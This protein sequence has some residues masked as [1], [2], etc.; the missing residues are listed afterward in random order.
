MF[1]WIGSP[2]EVFNE[3]MALYIKTTMDA[4]YAMMEEEAPKVQAFMRLSAS[5]Q[6]DCMPS[7]EYL[8]AVPYRDDADLVV[9]ILAYYDEEEYR[10]QCPEPE[11]DW[12]LVHELFT[13]PKAG[14]IS[15]I[16]PGDSPSLFNDDFPR[17]WDR[18]RALYA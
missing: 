18:V 10:R 7:R 15:V 4:L 16:L 6:D 5:W 9:G 8:K 13:F 2:V 12:G 3:G 11:F 1:K 14:K 17:V